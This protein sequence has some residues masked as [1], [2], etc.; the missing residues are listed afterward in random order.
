MYKGLLELGLDKISS[1]FRTYVASKSS[2]YTSIKKDAANMVPDFS[3]YLIQNVLLKNIHESQEKIDKNSS[4]YLIKK[5]NYLIKLESFFTQKLVEI[6]KY[7][8]NPIYTQNQNIMSEIELSFKKTLQKISLELDIVRYCYYEKQLS[9]SN[10]TNHSLTD[11]LY[12]TSRKKE[13]SNHCNIIYK[14]SKKNNDEAKDL[15]EKLKK[16]HTIYKNLSLKDFKKIPNLEI[17]DNSIEET[18]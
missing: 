7:K 8:S 1:L 5:V 3:D 13:I 18:R 4:K 15:K 9:I 17:K 12:Y 16:F 14:N 2:N 6:E 11:I 10:T